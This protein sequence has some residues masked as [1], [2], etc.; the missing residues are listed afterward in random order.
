M[1][2]SLI[3][4]LTLAIFAELAVAKKPKIKDCQPGYFFCGHAL[5]RMSTLPSKTESNHRLCIFSANNQ[6][7]GK[8]YFQPE[9]EAACQSANTTCEGD[10]VENHLFICYKAK[11][12][13]DDPDE[14]EKHFT[15]L[16]K[17]PG[18][19]LARPMGEVH[20]CPKKW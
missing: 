2:L 13:P 6:S 7:E 3:A 12:D 17:C 19:C 9:M 16:E 1:K 15:W 5:N 18:P 20:Y 4:S 11:K 8:G 14:K 10:S